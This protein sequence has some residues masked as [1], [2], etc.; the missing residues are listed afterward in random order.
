M[1]SIMQGMFLCWRR[2]LKEPQVLRDKNRCALAAGVA[3]A[4]FL[5]M[6]ATVLAFAQGGAMSP[7]QD[8]QDGVSAGG[9]W[10]EFR[11]KTR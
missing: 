8:E 10:M 6:T 9:L 4:T 5:F 3:F 7:Y 2:T 11:R 1:G